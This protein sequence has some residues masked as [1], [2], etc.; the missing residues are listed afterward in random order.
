MGRSISFNRISSDWHHHHA[1]HSITPD[2]A[3]KACWQT[4]KTKSKLRL[5]ADL[6]PKSFL[7]SSPHFLC[8][9]ACDLFWFL[10]LMGYWDGHFCMFGTTGRIESIDVVG[11]NKFVVIFFQTSFRVQM[12][13]DGLMCVPWCV[14]CTVCLPNWLRAVSFNMLWRGVATPPHLF[15]NF[16]S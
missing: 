15:F 6:N 3:S 11:T 13:N 14:H 10:L 7:S 5:N 16:F 9:T 2:A 1:L 4:Y 12:N 8:N